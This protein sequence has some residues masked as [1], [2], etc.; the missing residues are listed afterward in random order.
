MGRTLADR[1]PAA[2]PGRGTTNRTRGP[3]RPRPKDV[4]WLRGA[5]RKP[6]VRHTH[7]H[8]R[9]NQVA[10]KVRGGAKG[11]PL[12]APGLQITTKEWCI[13]GMVHLFPMHLDLECSEKRRTHALYCHVS[14]NMLSSFLG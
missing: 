10:P 5:C 1:R 3:T 6:Q 4:A 7:R 14:R 2:A 11:R 13:W 9:F 8:A 12:D